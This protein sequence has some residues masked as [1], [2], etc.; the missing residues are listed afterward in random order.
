VQADD[1]MSE[2]LDA[3]GPAGDQARAAAARALGAKK[4]EFYALGLVLGYDYCGSS[5]ITPAGDA[6]PTP[7]P[8][9][10]QPSAAA[11]AGPVSKAIAATGIPAV[12]RPVPAPAGRWDAPARGAVPVSHG[13]RAGTR[14]PGRREEA[15]EVEEASPAAAGT[16]V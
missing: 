15:A 13:R 12:V 10:Y 6:A 5:L 16:A 11:L 4:P 14:L 3:P 9:D 7:H 8:V 2:L 1:L